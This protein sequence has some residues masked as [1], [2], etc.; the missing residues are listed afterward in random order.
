MLRREFLLNMN[1]VCRVYGDKYR[2]NNSSVIAVIK[3]YIQNID[4][5]LVST[6]DDNILSIN[7]PS[8]DEICSNILTEIHGNPDIKS[9]RE[10][11][12]AGLYKKSFIIGFYFGALQLEAALYGK[13]KD[14]VLK[15]EKR[16]GK[17]IN[18]FPGM[19]NIC[20]VSTDEIGKQD[21]IDIYKSPVGFNIS[22][23]IVSIIVGEISWT[24]H[25][26][27]AYQV[28]DEVWLEFSEFTQYKDIFKNLNSSKSIVENLGINVLSY[29]LNTDWN[30]KS[31][32]PYKNDLL[33]TLR[34]YMEKREFTRE[35]LKKM[36]LMGIATIDKID[37]KEL[38]ILEILRR[39]INKE[40]EYRKNI[41]WVYK[42]SKDD[43]E[44]ILTDKQISVCKFPMSIFKHYNNKVNARL[45]LL[46]EL[47]DMN[48]YST[49]QLRG[50]ELVENGEKY[51]ELII[52]QY[53]DANRQI[54][55][56]Q[57]LCS[58]CSFTGDNL[59]EDN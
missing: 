33:M 16:Y 43:K 51:R 18:T 26:E 35:K 5:L 58:M 24:T 47:V 49:G 17:E 48:F 7:D 29:A 37:I 2:E 32:W 55:R 42:P 45:W 57:Q 1:S 13:T 15:L 19:V 20:S 39:L 9:V 53:R 44:Y 8:L 22:N 50:L 12:V 41:Q 56:L 23:A 3:K 10:M 36:Q 4:W 28:I 14:L 54:T 38:I 11:E 27:I 25:H 46:Y 31:F 59:F 30:D 34:Y 40:I 21:I 6:L 52:E